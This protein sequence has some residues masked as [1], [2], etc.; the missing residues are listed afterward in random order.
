MLHIS[1]LTLGFPPP[2]C[3]QSPTS[4]AKTHN[5]HNTGNEQLCSRSG[6]ICPL[7]GTSSFYCLEVKLH[8]WI[9]ALPLKMP[10]PDKQKYNIWFLHRLSYQKLSR[11]EKLSWRIR[12]LESVHICHSKTQP[13]LLVE[14]WHR[15]RYPFLVPCWLN[16]HA[17]HLHLVR[18]P[19]K[20][21]LTE[22]Q[23]LLQISVSQLLSQN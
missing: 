22:D 15:Y 12:E 6:I 13:W 16:A 10:L 9:P 4:C 7:V 19:L 18:S 20:A 23:C 3:S 17:D 1:V 14:C 21:H 2:Q 8:H 11:E 5:R